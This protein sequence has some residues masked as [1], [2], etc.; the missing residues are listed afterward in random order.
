MY[1]TNSI[2]KMYG[3]NTCGYNHN[4]NCWNNFYYELPEN[5]SI[6][7]NIGKNFGFLHIKI[8]CYCCDFI[9]NRIYLFHNN[10]TDNVILKMKPIFNEDEIQLNLPCGDVG[11]FEKYKVINS[12]NDNYIKDISIDLINKDIIDSEEWSLNSFYDK[13]HEKIK[14]KTKLKSLY[15]FSIKKRRNKTHDS[16]VYAIWFL[17][18]YINEPSLYKKIICLAK[19]W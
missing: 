13:L 11:S 3:Y 8:K 2:F 18:K 19:M 14:L 6:Y 5:V 4:N 9:D 17:S 15:K 10:N 16:R 7:L 1:P 12:V